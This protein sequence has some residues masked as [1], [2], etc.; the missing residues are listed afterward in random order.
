MTAPAL[1]IALLL[2][3]TVAFELGRRRAL[4]VSGAQ[5]AQLH[6]RPRYYGSFTAL[7]CLLPA[8]VV[9]VL[10][11]FFEQSIT[12][13]ILI[14]ELPDEYGALPPTELR[15]LVSDIRN[16]AATGITTQD[17][18]VRAGIERYLELQTVAR[19]AMSVT[20]LALA[21]IGLSLSWSGS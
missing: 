7:W 4:A 1:L 17:P 9:T 8:L 11:L 3:T 20:V 19:A 2:L 18:A 14:S 13:Q 15:L 10:W 16:Q 5:I 6:S 12:T 21:M